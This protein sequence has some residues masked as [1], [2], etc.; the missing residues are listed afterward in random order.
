MEKE[1]LFFWQKMEENANNLD[2]M[3]V[4]FM[5]FMIH[6]FKLKS[7]LFSTL[8]N[9]ATY[10]HPQ[11]P[12]GDKCS[13]ETIKY[14][15]RISRRTIKRHIKILISKN[16]LSESNNFEVN[17]KLIED[18]FKKFEKDKISREWYKKL[19]FK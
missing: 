5:V 13:L 1:G 9:I 8:S 15:L 16:L 18:R 3:D 17:F 19:K 11:C 2:D 7:G 6:E 12:D 4:H 10:Y 14:H